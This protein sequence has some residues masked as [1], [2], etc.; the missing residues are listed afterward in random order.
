M[1]LLLDH[2][3]PQR[4]GSLL[5]DHEVRTAAERAWDQ[6]RNGKLLAAAEAEG[7]VVLLTVDQGMRHQQNMSGRRI[8]V[9]IMR[10]ATNSLRDL[11]PLV[12]SVLAVLPS[13]QPGSV[14][15]IPPRP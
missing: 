6:L 5:E 3:V 15:E 8:A 4:L 13:L 7:F 10:A 12:P 9:L 14:T 1:R 2:C 11:A